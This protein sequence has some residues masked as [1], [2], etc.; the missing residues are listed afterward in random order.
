EGE[1]PAGPVH[2]IGHSMGGLDARFMVAKLGMETRVL[3]LTTVGTPHRGSPF[4]DWG[5]SRFARLVVPVLRAVGIP[6]EAFLDLTTDG[7][8]DYGRIVRRLAAAGF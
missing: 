1:L 6:H 8:P 3:S 4:A 2:V 5:V 7:C